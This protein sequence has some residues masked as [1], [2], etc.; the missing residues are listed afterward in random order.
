MIHVIGQSSSDTCY[1]SG[2]WWYITCY[3]SGLWWYML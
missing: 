2:L 1:R 3:R